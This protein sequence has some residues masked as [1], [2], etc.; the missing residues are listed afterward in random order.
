MVGL[1][2]GLGLGLVIIWREKNIGKISV[3]KKIRKI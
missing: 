3:V 1:G 2:L